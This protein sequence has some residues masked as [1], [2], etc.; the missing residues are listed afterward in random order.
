MQKHA[1]HQRGS[2]YAAAS[3]RLSLQLQIRGK[4]TL[5]RNIGSPTMQLKALL[6]IRYVD[7]KPLKCNS[8]VAVN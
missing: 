5:M 2:G 6:I 7:N 3:C 8:N 1:D 4:T